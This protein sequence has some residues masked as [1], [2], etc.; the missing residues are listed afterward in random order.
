MYAPLGDVRIVEHFA[1]EAPLALRIAAAMTGRLAR[2]LGADVVVIEDEGSDPLRLA[3]P[4]IAGGSALHLFLNRGKRSAGSADAS[5]ELAAAD[6]VIGSD[7]AP[8]CVRFTMAGDPDRPGSEFTTLADAGILDLVGAEQGL[9]MRL[10]GHQAAYAAGLAGYAGLAAALAGRAADHGYR[11]TVLVDLLD[12][13]VWINWKAVGS[14]AWGEA[15]PRRRD[16][17]EW[18]PVRCRDGHVALVYRDNDWPALCDMIGDPRL[19][20]PA[21]ATRPERARNMAQLVAI[22]EE[23]FAPFTRAELLSRS[24][25]RK[26]PLG[27]I[28]SPAELADDIQYAARDFLEMLPLP[29]GGHA[30][31]PRLP[32]LSL[33]G[34]TQA[35]GSAT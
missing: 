22:V 15:V 25:V 4:Q 27:P 34:G 28:L 21:F 26:L 12:T 9:P 11:E 29:G 16:D 14:V 8:I 31:A 23:A 32:C 1:P 35:S 17:A 24:M 10:G 3:H 5:R 30:M 20:G 19:N 18:R 13:G 33:R 2:D 7:G 6:A